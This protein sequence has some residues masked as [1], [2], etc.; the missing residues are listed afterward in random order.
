MGR[1][2]TVTEQD[3]LKADDRAAKSA[4]QYADHL[5]ALKLYESLCKDFLAALMMEIRQEM[6][7]IK[8]SQSELETR[9]RS[10]PKWIEFRDQ[11]MQH[12]K[13]AG[14]RE[15]RYKNDQRRWETL[16]SLI[17]LKKSEIKRME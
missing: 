17:S 11:Q 3:F 1:I 12:L 4:E 9:A 16:R 5:H 2:L 10:N 13:D 14:R 8:V 7:D 6:E 15:I